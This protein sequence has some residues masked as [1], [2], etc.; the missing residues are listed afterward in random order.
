MLE[1]LL[2]INAI[3]FAM[4]FNVFAIRNRIFAKLLVPP[5]QRDTPV[6]DILASSGRFLG[7]FNFAFMVLNILLLL[8][9]AA[10]PTNEQ[11]AI[12]L[13]VVAVAHGSQFIY[14]LPVYIQNKRG[15]GIWQVKGTMEFIFVTDFILMGLNAALASLLFFQ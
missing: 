1:T 3:W 15:L 4:G 8:K 10:F 5:D 13:F 12:L 7:G 11:R 9:L 14:N 2:V 6:F